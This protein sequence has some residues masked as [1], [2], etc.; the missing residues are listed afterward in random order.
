M[1]GRVSGGEGAGWQP[2]DA[3][4]AQTPAHRRW[5]TLILA[6]PFSEPG[7]VRRQ[8]DE[9]PPTPTRT[10]RIPIAAQ[11]KVGCG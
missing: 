4:K 6:V 3:A 8:G 9:T 1:R 11:R 10:L 2:L 5:C 7:V